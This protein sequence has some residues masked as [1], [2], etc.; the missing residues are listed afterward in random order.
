MYEFT[1]SKYL[2]EVVKILESEPKFSEKLR[3]MPEADIKVRR[4]GF[5]AASMYV[6]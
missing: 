3:G 5:F 6:Y 2:E 1:Y 4:L